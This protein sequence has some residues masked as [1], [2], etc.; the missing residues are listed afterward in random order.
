[1]S[2][3]CLV[4][5]I[6]TTGAKISVDDQTAMPEHFQIAIPQR[7]IDRAARLVWRRAGSAG[8]AFEAEAEAV[9]DAAQGSQ[10]R[11]Q[12]LEAENKALRATIE[13]LTARLREF[14][15]GY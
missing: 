14:G 10:T 6:S 7:A 9:S 11:L 1:M 3:S 2:F 15:E 8:I 12:A 4:T 5:K 13:S